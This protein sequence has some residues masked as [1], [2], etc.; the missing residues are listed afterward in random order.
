MEREPL[1][2]LRRTTFDTPEFRGIEFIEVEAKS[3]INR[4]PGTFL[5]FN[6]T[7]NPYRGCSHACVYCHSGETPVLLGDG[8]TR[9]I[10][11]LNV[12]DEIYGTERRGVCRRYVKTHVLAHWRTVKPA[13]RTTLEDGTELVTSGDHRFLS[14]RGWKYVIGADQGPGHRPFLTT[15]N[16]LLGTGRFA[17]GPRDTSEYRRGYLCGMTRGDGTIGTYSYPRPGRTH[18][19]VHRFRPALVDMEGIVRTR[20]YLDDLSIDTTEFEYRLAAGAV[21]AARAIRTSKRAHIEAIRA[22]CDWPREPTLDWCKGFLAGIFDAEGGYKQGVFRISS[23]N[24]EILGKI[25]SS[26][27][28]LRFA[29]RIED[30]PAGRAST[31][32]IL[33]GL[34]EVLR[35]FHTVDPAIRRKRDIEGRA[36][37]GPAVKD[38]PSLRVASIEDLGIELP[39]YDITTGTGDFIA[40]GVVSHNCFAR[41]THTYMD[42]NAGRDFESKIVVKVNAPEVLRRQLARKSWKAE[43]IAMGTATDPYQR[44][45]GRYKLMSGIIRA[46]TDYR[47]SF[48]ILTKGTLILRDLDLLLHAANVTDVGTALS[49]DTLDEDAWRRAEPGT[50]H[51]KKRM[52]AVAA[53]NDAGIPCGVM[54]AP[55]LPGITDDRAKLRDVVTAAIDAGATH[56]SPIM[57]HLRPVV[58]DEYMRWLEDEFPELVSRYDA[59]YAKNAYGPVA[60]RKRTTGAVHELVHEAGGLRLKPGIQ[61]RFRHRG[62]DDTTETPPVGEQLTFPGA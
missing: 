30:G 47:N 58:R 18:F 38:S 1:F 40:N 8:T 39:M 13:Y 35:F 55:I 15:N 11:D 19:D 45:E 22:I 32:R 49:I 27:R 46:L 5:P 57:L 31:L 48:S 9:P 20:R 2:E 24:E 28:R 29:Y 7:I 50:P 61:P 23:T 12:G 52:E 60:D 56:V 26:L 33:G 10:A 4:V 42:M 41:V 16:K 59:M 53:L 3:V 44:A 36:L 25:A 62:R 54:V 21:S 6:W 34:R 43:H 17:E 37:K 14:D 51:P